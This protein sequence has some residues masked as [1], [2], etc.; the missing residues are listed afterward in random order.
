MKVL[1]VGDAMIPGKRLALLQRSTSAG[2]EQRWKSSIGRQRTK[3]SCRIDAL[4]L[5]KTVLQP[6][7]LLRE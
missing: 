5:K 2:T 7:H 3:W 6:R 1:V 4:T